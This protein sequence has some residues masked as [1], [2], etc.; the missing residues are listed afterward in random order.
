MPSGQTNDEAISICF[1]L[2]DKVG[3]DD[4]AGNDKIYTNCL[5]K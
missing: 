4:E 2:N 1:L 5:D 3:Q